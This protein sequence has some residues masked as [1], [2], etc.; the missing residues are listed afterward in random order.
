MSLV[1]GWSLGGWLTADAAV[2]DAPLLE[3]GPRGE[4]PDT[5]EMVLMLPGSF[6]CA[7]NFI[8]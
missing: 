5:A 2:G 3:S 4:F 7:E 6:D 1:A 8:S